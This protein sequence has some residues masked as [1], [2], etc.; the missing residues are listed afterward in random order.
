MPQSIKTLALVEHQRLFSLEELF[1]FLKTL[2]ETPSTLAGI[3]TSTV[4]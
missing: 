1:Y 4:P 2:T 3:L